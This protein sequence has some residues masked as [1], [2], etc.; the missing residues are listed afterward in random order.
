M[1][2]LPLLAWL[3]L[4]GALFTLQRLRL[5]ASPR[6][7]HLAPSGTGFGPKKHSGTPARIA[8]ARSAETG[9]HGRSV[10]GMDIVTLFTALRTGSWRASALT[11]SKAIAE[12]MVRAMAG[13]G[14]RA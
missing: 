4:Q 8:A 13:V 7:I 11:V 10:L 14:R 6:K 9:V 1:T 2:H 12:K 5:Q 3:S